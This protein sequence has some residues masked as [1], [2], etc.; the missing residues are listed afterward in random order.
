M[1][2]SSIS[3]ISTLSPLIRLARFRIIT[4]V[5]NVTGSEP[6]RGRMFAASVISPVLYRSLNRTRIS[7]GA[8]NTRCRSWFN[9]WMR[10]SRADLR[11]TI[12]TRICSTGPFRPFGVTDASPKSRSSA[13]R[14]SVGSDFPTLRRF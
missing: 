11:A 13:A 1:S 3:P 10:C 14:A 6:L 4:Y 7:S 5:V 2:I 12:N 8:V 9:V